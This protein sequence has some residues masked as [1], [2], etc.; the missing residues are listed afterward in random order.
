VLASGGAGS[1]YHQQ[2]RERYGVCTI[3]IFFVRWCELLVS[4]PWPQ[5]RESEDVVRKPL[6]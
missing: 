4:K 1:F 5:H 3:G 6:S 2:V